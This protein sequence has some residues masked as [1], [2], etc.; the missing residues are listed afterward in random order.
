L[1]GFKS[2]SN[3]SAAAFISAAVGCPPGVDDDN[4]GAADDI[5]AASAFV[6]VVVIV[7]NRIDDKSE[8]SNDGSDKNKES[9]K[10]IA[11]H[12]GVS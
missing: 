2:D 3:A 10:S 9:I 1:G 7:L 8:S 11:Q 6:S 5:D 12:E 4:R